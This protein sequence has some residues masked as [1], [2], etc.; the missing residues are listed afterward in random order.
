MKNIFKRVKNRVT[1][2]TGRKQHIVKDVKEIH[3]HRKP[4]GTVDDTPRI[5]L[6]FPVFSHVLPEAFASFMHLALHS[7]R[8]LPQYKFDVMLCER[9][10]LHSAMNRAA[11]L[12]IK[13]PWYIGM[14]AFDDDCIIPANAVVR[15]A[16]H[17]EHGHHI[18]AG[19]GFMRRYPHTTT[20]GTLLDSG[21]TIFHDPGVI[22]TGEQRGFKWLDDC[23]ELKSR[24]DEHGLVEVDFCGMPAMFISRKVLHD[25]KTPHFMHEDK[26]GAVTT[27]DIY[28]CNKARD[29]GHKVMVDMTL[30][31]GHIGPSPVIT[32][33][34]RKWARVAVETKETAD[35]GD[36]KTPGRVS[37]RDGNHGD[38]DRGQ[39]QERVRST[40]EE[41]NPV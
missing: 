15:F 26:T 21:P 14:V 4:D 24:A 37:G 18:I 27:H 11:E 20:V 36:S 9:E 16:A 3:Y 30:E 25:M 33:Q 31:C 34:T 40:S 29:M 12:C 8:W 17:Y 7:A 39:E 2:P 38:G 22:Q 32:E 19:Y 6:V 13:N 35:G 10:L 1:D 5:L 28:F 23:D 41:R